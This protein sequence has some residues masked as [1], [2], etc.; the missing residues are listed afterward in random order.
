MRTQQFLRHFSYN[1][2]ML[3]V[4][5]SIMPK[6]V[7]ALIIVLNCKLH[8]FKA[9]SSDKL[10]HLKA[11][12]LQQSLLTRPLR[13]LWKTDEMSKYRSWHGNSKQNSVRTDLQNIK[14]SCTLVHV[15][16]SFIH[17]TSTYMTPPL[18]RTFGMIRYRPCLN[19]LNMHV[20]E[21]FVST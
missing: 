19:R 17:V 1:L 7:I 13:K 3:S 21:A 20:N 11:M 6:S 2:K 9:I 5:Y 18:Q 15:V 8:F 16:K 4:G 14:K 12:T 10:R